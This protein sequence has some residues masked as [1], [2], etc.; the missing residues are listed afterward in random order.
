MIYICREFGWDYHTYMAQPVWFLE[1]V[2]QF[3]DTEN[4]ER[5]KEQ[6]RLNNRYGNR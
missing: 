5:E 6:R 1:H 4:K 2:L 3:L